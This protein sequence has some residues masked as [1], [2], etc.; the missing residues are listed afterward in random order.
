MNPPIRYVAFNRVPPFKKTECINEILQIPCLVSQ[1]RA[2][3]LH[4]CGFSPYPTPALPSARP[5][6][7]R[8][9]PRRPGRRR[10]APCDCG[11]GYAGYGT[12][13]GIGLVLLRWGVHKLR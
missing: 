13:G 4:L 8:L 11:R 5:Q 3:Y 10:G 6:T 7:A 12:W 1:G 9:T 2:G